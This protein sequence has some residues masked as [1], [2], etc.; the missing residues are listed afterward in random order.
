MIS[1]S[2][3]DKG[4]AKEWVPTGQRILV[5]GFSGLVG[6]GFVK[7]AYQEDELICVSRGITP[8]SFR[9]NNKL[10]IVNLDL[11]VNPVDRIKYLERILDRSQPTLILHFAAAADVDWCQENKE[12]AFDANVGL[13]YCLAIASKNKGIPLGLCSTDY[14]FPGRGPFSEGDT[15]GE[16]R[17]K[18][19]YL[20][21]YSYTKLRA[22]EIIEE[23]LFPHKLGFIFR[24]AFPY[25]HHYLRRPGT[26]VIAFYTLAQ[27]KRWTALKDMHMTV[28]PTSDIAYSLNR[29]IHDRVWERKRP[30]YHIA[31]PDILTGL[32]I[33]TICIE[34]LKRRGIEVHKNQIVASTVSEFFTGDRAPRQVCGGLRTDKIRGM[35]ICIS[36]LCEKIKNFPLPED[37]AALS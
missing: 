27:G 23:I 3:C 24:I 7:I 6:Y 26:P 31:G 10:Q 32:D 14:V 36:S 13:T 16:I 22:E 1:E 21:F 28:T 2:L 18:E 35:G 12:K 5:T 8:H 33:A 37:W 11:P 15:R 29:L 4:E 9:E 34:E 17:N 30:I 19:G 20:N 25:D